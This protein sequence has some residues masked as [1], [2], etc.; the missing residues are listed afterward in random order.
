VTEKNVVAGSSIRLKVEGITPYAVLALISGR[1]DGD[2][3]EPFG[4]IVVPY[5]ESLDAVVRIPPDAEGGTYIFFAQQWEPGG[6]PAYPGGALIY[7]SGAA[8]VQVQPRIDDEAFWKSFR[9][10]SKEDAEEIRENI[11]RSR[12]R[13]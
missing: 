5:E 6:A 9:P 3:L 1:L 4:R 2:P 8:S 7:P 13:L 12:E 11:R 10:W